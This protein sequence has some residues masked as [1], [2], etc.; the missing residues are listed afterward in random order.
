MYISNM[1][2]FLF[3]L[4]LFFLGKKGYCNDYFKFNIGLPII[5]S[6]KYI[7]VNFIYDL[8]GYDEKDFIVRANV[9]N[10]YV[11]VNDKNENVGKYLWTDMPVL[12]SEFVIKI[13]TTTINTDLWFDVVNQ[14]TGDIYTTNKKTIWNYSVITDYINRLNKNYVR[15]DK[16]H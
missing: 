15:D 10:G 8:E 7:K 9:S 14:K 1:L 16:M 12:S 4:V 13:H 6:S 3:Y 5:S 11:Q 2:K